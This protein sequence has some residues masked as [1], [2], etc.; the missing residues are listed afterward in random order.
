MSFI[1]IS[2]GSVALAGN[3]LYQAKDTGKNHILI[4]EENPR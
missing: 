4:R 1:E 3:L 2:A